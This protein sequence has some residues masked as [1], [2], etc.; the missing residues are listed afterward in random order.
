MAVEQWKEVYE[1][2]VYEVSNLGRIR[3]KENGRV[4]NARSITKGG[5][6]LVCLSWKNKIHTK[7]L[8]R[9][10]AKAFIPNPNNL[11][12]VNHKK[13]KENCKAQHLEWR[14]SRGNKVDAVQRE[15]RGTGV[16]FNAQ[17]GK[18]HARYNPSPYKR[19]HLGFFS[20]KR[21]AKA[22]RKAAVNTLPRNL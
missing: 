16:Y 15:L 14:S 22:A 1:V 7:L 18:W 9:L 17:V 2:P 3:R 12:E 6:L 13:N 5:Y 8:S 10:V 19:K 11:P 21:E 20:T 4:L